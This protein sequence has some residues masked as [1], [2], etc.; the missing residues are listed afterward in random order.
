[1][2]F[3]VVFLAYVFILSIFT[4]TTDDRRACETENER[5]MLKRKDFLRGTGVTVQ[6]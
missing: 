3:K 1:M 6:S 4:Y 5:L 2:N